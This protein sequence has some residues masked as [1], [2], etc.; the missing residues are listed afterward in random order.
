MCSLGLQGVLDQ[1]LAKITV[2]KD[3]AAQRQNSSSCQATRQWQK[4]WHNHLQNCW[5]LLRPAIEEGT[6]TGP[7]VG[8]LATPLALF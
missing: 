4:G 8:V 3:T 7:E 2:P 5:T 1:P 6:Q